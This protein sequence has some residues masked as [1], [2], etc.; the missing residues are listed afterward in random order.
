[1]YQ[2]RVHQTT[3]S[4]FVPQVRVVIND[5]VVGDS[6]QLAK[7]KAGWRNHAQVAEEKWRFPNAFSVGESKHVVILCGKHNLAVL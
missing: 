1:M 7:D 2:F 3:I 6:C 4:K 5:V